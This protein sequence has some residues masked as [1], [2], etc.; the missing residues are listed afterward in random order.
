MT[1]LWDISKGR[2]LG[3]HLSGFTRY[4][5]DLRGPRN[6]PMSIKTL[7]FIGVR[8][9]IPKSEA[10]MNLQ[11]LQSFTPVPG[12][13]EASKRVARGDLKYLSIDSLR[14]GSF[15]LNWYMKNAVYLPGP[16]S[17]SF[18]TEER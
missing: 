8:A 5:I 14:Y 9:A 18:S 11:I 6:I 13:S 4:K 15:F 12:N 10:R 3:W 16:S 17:C 7:G 1:I 2:F